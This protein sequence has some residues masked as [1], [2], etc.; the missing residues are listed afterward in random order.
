M[1]VWEEYVASG[2]C[3]VHYLRPPHAV[4][5]DGCMLPLA[6]CEFPSLKAAIDARNSKEYVHDVIGAAGKPVEEIATRDFRIIEAPNT[7]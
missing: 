2:A 4:Y 5:E 3:T 6:V 7:N 1:P